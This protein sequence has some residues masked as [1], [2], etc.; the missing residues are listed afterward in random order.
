MNKW[1]ALIT[2]LPTE[3]ATARMRAWRS[4]K[5]SG[6][7]VLRD[8]VYLMPERD[9]CRLT[10]DTVAADVLAAGGSAL[11][12]RIEE[13]DGATFP[14]LFNRSEDYATLLAEIAKS[15]VGLDADTATDALKQARKLRK[16]LASLVE[17]D[18]FP[19]EA[20]RQAETALQDMELMA[21]RALSPDE[22]HPVESAIS[23]LE[24]STYRRRTWATRRRPWVD[25]LASAWLIYRFI[26]PE[27]HLLWLDSPSHC[28]SEALGFDFDGATF[29]HVGARVTFEVLLASFGLETPALQR[30]GALVHFLDVGGVQPPESA[31]IESALAGLRETISDDDQLLTLAGAVFDGLLASFEKGAKP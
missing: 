5:A 23:H 2:S 31:G 24:I 12:L 17:I 7:A 25:R 27:A 10:L 8:G 21:G 29:S 1:I 16:A 28:P 3:N 4:L 15:R 30:L 14:D 26:D 18:F 9:A 20:R 19:G 22:P 11:V 6:A 13:P